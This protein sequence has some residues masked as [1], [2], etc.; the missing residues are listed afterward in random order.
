MLVFA[1]PFGT[2]FSCFQTDQA[3]IFIRKRRKHR[4][5]SALKARTRTA[6]RRTRRTFCTLARFLKTSLRAAPPCLP[7]ERGRWVGPR[8]SEKGAIRKAHASFT[9]RGR[10]RRVPVADCSGRKTL[11]R[12]L[13]EQEP[14]RPQRNRLCGTR[15]SCRAP[16]RSHGAARGRPLH[17]RVG[18]WRRRAPRRTRT[19]ATGPPESY[20]AFVNL[21]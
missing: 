10:Q 12:D 15:R 14:G 20:G 6:W 2:A 16:R 18:V 4:A 1:R 21:A 5:R 11:S 9:I 17:N 7:R 13:S 3:P 19:P 8:V